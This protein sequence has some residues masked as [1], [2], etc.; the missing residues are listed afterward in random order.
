MSEVPSRG[1]ACPAFRYTHVHQRFAKLKAHERL[2]FADHLGH[3]LSVQGYLA[4]KKTR[5]PRTLQ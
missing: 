5:S 1:G 2:A 3:G 4:Y